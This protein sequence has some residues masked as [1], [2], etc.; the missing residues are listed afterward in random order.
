MVQTKCVNYKVALEYMRSGYRGK[1]V[2]VTSPIVPAQLTGFLIIAETD[3]VI[4]IIPE[5]NSKPLTVFA[6]YYFT[7]DDKEIRKLEKTKKR[8]VFKTI[9]EQGRVVA[10]KGKFKVVEYNGK[11]FIVNSN[12]VYYGK[13]EEHIIEQLT[14]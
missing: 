6:V 13:F 7:G 3:N 9:V 10:E 5:Y 2:R 1:E 11:Y 14:V 12:S 4:Y 8:K